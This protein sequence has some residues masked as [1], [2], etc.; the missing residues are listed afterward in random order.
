MGKEIK[1]GTDCKRVEKE[2]PK[3]DGDFVTGIDAAQSYIMEEIWS[4][5]DDA[6]THQRGGIQERLTNV[7]LMLDDL[8]GEMNE[9]LQEDK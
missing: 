1:H 2:F 3:Y 9:K 4:I 6:M 7:R 8:L 5:E